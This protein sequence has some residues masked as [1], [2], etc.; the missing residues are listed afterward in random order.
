MQV[1]CGSQ[2]WIDAPGELLLPPGFESSSGPGGVCESLA[3]LQARLGGL[4]SS[5]CGS[6][7]AAYALYCPGGIPSKCSAICRPALELVGRT[8]AALLRDGGDTL[9]PVQDSLDAAMAMC[10]RD[11]D[12]SAGGRG[13]GG[14]GH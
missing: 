10:R 6:D 14:G 3:D 7:P 2:G 12:A 8:C 5:C 13:G 11:D 1:Q 9:A 4:E